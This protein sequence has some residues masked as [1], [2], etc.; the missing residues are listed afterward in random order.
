MHSET[1]DPDHGW[2]VRLLIDNDRVRA[3]YAELVDACPRA[4]VY[5][6]P[7]WLRV[8]TDLG[9]DLVYVEIDSDAMLPFVCKGGGA[10]RRAYSLPFDTYG[11]PVSAGPQPAV[12][13]ERVVE[14]LGLETVRVA[15][16][17]DG[18][19]SSNGAL[20]PA[21]SHIVDLSGGYDDAVHRYTDSNLRLIRQA[22]RHGVRVAVMNDPRGV[23]EFHRLHVRTVARYGA[24][25]LPL[26]F[27]EAVHA[28]MAPSGRAVFY[29]AY[30]NGRVVG[31]NLVFRFRDRAYD[32]MWV[33]DDKFLDLR[34]T[35]LMIDRAIRDE[36][37]RGGTGLNLGAS[38]NE[39]LGSVRFKQSFGATSHPYAVYTHAGALIS[40][41][42]RVRDGFA[43]IG[44]RPRDGSRVA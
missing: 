37:A 29:L 5:Q 17:A 35:N 34:A 30:H 36:A 24:R 28:R 32:W 18:V 40:A 19:C 20:R 7:E 39:R 43:R 11:G 13:F 15:D 6:T 16:F 21:R 8:W 1:T 31:G 10:L 41:A 3:R 38:P 14:S 22:D 23:R 33:Y 27:F 12:S 25:P 2:N 4:T 44:A 42:R 9:A 26:R